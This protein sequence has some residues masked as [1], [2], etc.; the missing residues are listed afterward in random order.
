LKSVLFLQGPLGSFFSDLAKYFHQ[1]QLPTF[2]INFNGGDRHF[3]WA[4]Q[5]DN[6]T[7]QPDQWSVYLS[8]YIKNHNINT[9]IVYGDCRFYHQQAAQVAEQLGINFW[10]FE[11]GYLRAGFITLEQGGCNANSLLDLSPQAML[12]ANKM[13]SNSNE[14]VGRTFFKRTL[15]AALYYWQIKRGINNF[16]HYTHHRPW[17]WWQEAGFW[18]NNFKQKFIS[19]CSDPIALKAFTKKYTHNYY[20]LPLQVETDFQMRKHSPFNSVAE[21]LRYTLTSFAKHA[22]K[23][24]ALLIKHHPQSRGFEHYGKLISTLAKK[25]GITDRV[26]YIHQANLP[27]LYQQ[28]KGVVTV[29][30]TVGLSALQHYLPTITLGKAIYDI[31]GVT[32]Q[33]ELS[34]FWQSSYQVDVKLLTAFHGYL[35]HNTQIP[36]D[37]YKPS[38]RFIHS[39]FEKIVAR[40]SPVVNFSADTSSIKLLLNERNHEQ[41]HKSEHNREHGIVQP[42]LSPSIDTV[43]HYENTPLT[44]A[45]FKKVCGEV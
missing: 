17:V 45:A 40:Q 27:K 38:E 32:F 29:N 16:A 18:F 23:S 37:F 10:V 8:K 12:Q 3:G 14:Q 33:G 24:D 21:S 28:C 43:D 31:P 19:E 34:D 7:G 22:N 9:V 4:N 11:E 30:S 25:L 2:K 44:A 5:I 35:Q 6:Y 1:Q 41:E 36:G 20:L 39:V 42:L 13:P 15:S 26:L